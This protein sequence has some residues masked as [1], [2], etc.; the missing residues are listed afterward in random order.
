MKFSLKQQ[1]T[2]VASGESGEVIAR[3]EYISGDPQYLVRYK[4]ADG[5]AVEIWW[6]EAALKG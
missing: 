1:V 3:A 6:T 4:A 5:R 2:I